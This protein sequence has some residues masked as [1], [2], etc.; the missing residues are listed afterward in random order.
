[1]TELVIIFYR[2]YNHKCFQENYVY[3][4]SKI[5][6]DCSIETLIL[7]LKISVQR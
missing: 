6:S 7:R 2:R 4:N 5:P 1:M 3:K